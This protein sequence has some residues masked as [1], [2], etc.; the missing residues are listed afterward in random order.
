MD[1]SQLDEVARY[2]ENHEVDGLDK[3]CIV[4]L[5]C[6]K[7]YYHLFHLICSWLCE[8]F[9]DTY[10]CAG[11]KTHQSIRVAC[12]LLAEKLQDKDFKKLAMKLKQLHD[13]RVHADYRLDR[14]FSKNSI[15]LMT[16]EKQK[17]I[18]LIEKLNKTYLQA[19]LMKA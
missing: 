8:K 3:E 5:S 14:V 4:R 13:L 9:K 2:L 19:E 1:I 10:E 15:Y 18:E 11:G 6:S 7:H 12:E 16:I 17:I